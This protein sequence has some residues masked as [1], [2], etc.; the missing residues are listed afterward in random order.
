MKLE[1][2]ETERLRTELVNQ[3]KNREGFIDKLR[4]EYDYIFK[5]IDEHPFLLEMEKG[6]LP[7]EKYKTYAVQNFFYFNEWFRC[8]AAAAAKATT[9]SETLKFKK[10]MTDTNPEY[11][12][13]VALI[14]EV[15]MS[16][17]QLRE[18][19]VNPAIPL[20]A[21]RA[22]VDYQFKIYSTASAGEMAAAILPCAW[23]YSPRELGG[24]ACPLRI[25]KGLADHYG[26][27]REI[28]LDYG[29]YSNHRPHFELL[30]SLKKSISE[31]VKHGKTGV[32]DRI[33][34]IF[35][36]CSEYEYMWWDLAYRHNLEKE[37]EI[38]S[39]F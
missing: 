32:A 22:Y 24:V 38:G 10:W 19:E 35:R 4:Y 26:V 11:D 37:R 14:K 9:T 23:S 34:D 28:A 31:E 21:A 1:D 36:R 33:R 29:N 18:V 12:K 5:K 8:C 7:I 13:Y 3:Y 25:G 30:L 27:N 17:A 20:P 6:K 15:G 16:D 39:Y 2:K